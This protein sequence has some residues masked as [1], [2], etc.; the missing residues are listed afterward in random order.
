MIEPARKVSAAAPVATAAGV[1]IFQVRV[2]YE[3]TDAGGVVYY[4]NYLKFAERARSE[5]LR[6]LGV[7][8]V[9][10]MQEDGVAFAVRRCEADYI[11]PARLDD[12]LEVAT[13]LVEVGGASLVA[14]Q[15]I[16]RDGVDLVRLRIALACMTRAGRPARMPKELKARLENFSNSHL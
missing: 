11:K 13:R 15:A 6:A 5:M 7:D 14:E 3:D 1:H 16:R 2:Y 10:L 12:L 4:A 8:N 9:R